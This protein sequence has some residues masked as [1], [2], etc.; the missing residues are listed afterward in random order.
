MISNSKPSSIINAVEYDPD[1]KD[2]TVTLHGGKTYTYPDTTAE[3]HNAFVSADSH[4]RHFAAVVS[5]RPH[6]LK[7]TAS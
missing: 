3:E 2:L 4:G 7:N 1:S 5:K 6:R